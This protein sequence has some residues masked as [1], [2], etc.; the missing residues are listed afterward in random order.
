MECGSALHSVAVCC[1]ALQCVDVAVRCS[2]LQCVAV[3][4]N[5][6]QCVAV[7]CT[8]LHCVALCCTVLHCV[9]LC[10]SVLQH[11]APHCTTLQHT[12]THCN[13]LTFENVCHPLQ[14]K[15]QGVVENELRQN[16]EIL[17][18]QLPA[19]HSAQ[20]YYRDD[21]RE[22]LLLGAARQPVGHSKRRHNC[23]TI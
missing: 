22:F 5:A 8:V 2:A 11:T 21:F 3:R 17:K 6:L 1:N 23:A 10:G 12:A 14:D 16:L 13:T 4:C 7:C 15:P 18:T 9:A 19:K 20:K